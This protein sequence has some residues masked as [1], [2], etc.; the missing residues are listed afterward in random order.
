MKDLNPHFIP[1]EEKIVKVENLHIKRG[2]NRI[3]ITW[4]TGEVG[5]IFFSS[6]KEAKYY[7]DW[8]TGNPKHPLHIIAKEHYFNQF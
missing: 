5:S 1:N 3:V 8:I 4:N 6:K 7:Y 2:E